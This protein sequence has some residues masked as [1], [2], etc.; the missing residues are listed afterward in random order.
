MFSFF[1]FYYL[2]LE[3]KTIYDFLYMYLFQIQLLYRLLSRSTNQSNQCLSNRRMI[4]IKHVLLNIEFLW[5]NSKVL[6]TL[7]FV[8]LMSKIQFRCLIDQNEEM[9]NIVRPFRVDD[10][11]NRAP[12]LNCA[13]RNVSIQFHLTVWKIWI[14]FSSLLTLQHL[15]KK[16]IK[17]HLMPWKWC[18]FFG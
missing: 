17:E 15:C 16:N 5:Q 9:A 2:R 1:F 8:L 12:D 3:R 4:S 7:P 6:S 13:Y 14:I 10:E 18:L 11:M